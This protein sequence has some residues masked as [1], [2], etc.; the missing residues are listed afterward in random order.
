MSKA[1]EIFDQLRQTAPLRSGRAYREFEAPSG[2]SVRAFVDGLTRVPGIAFTTARRHVPKDIQFPRFRGASVQVLRAPGGREDEVAFEVVPAER[3]TEEVFVELAVQLIDAVA[4]ESSAEGG[5]LRL[6]R[7]MSAWS[8]FFSARGADGLARSEELGL[9]GELLFL[10]MLG[11]HTGLQA[12]VDGWSG[13]AGAQHDFQGPWGAVEVKLTTSSSPERFRITSERQL[14]E[15]T[16]HALFLYSVVAQE[17]ESAK[18][19]L[20]GLVDLLREQID[21][22]APA[23]RTR[24]DECLCE[25]GYADADRSKYLIRLSVHHAALLKV[26]GDFPRIRH[27]DLRS[28]VFS[29]TYEIPWASVAPYRVR[30]ADIPYLFTVPQK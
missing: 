10:E 8:R 23:A 24:F 9:M 4:Q 5:L 15:T 27:D 18:T 19:S 14:D 7:S 2:L 21:R 12:A 20:A 3:S 25:V 30:E 1:S 26:H 17:A 22:T 11:S 28:G 16:V 13:P 29:V 6:A